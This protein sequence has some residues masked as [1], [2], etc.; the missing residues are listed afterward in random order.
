MF[1]SDGDGELTWEEFVD[2]MKNQFLIEEENKP[3]LPDEEPSEVRM[4][5]QTCIHNMYV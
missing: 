2:F 3:V 5:A 1:D 4:C